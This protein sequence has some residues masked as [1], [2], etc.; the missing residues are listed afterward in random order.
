[1]V[2]VPSY[3]LLKPLLMPARA[4]LSSPLPRR[5]WDPRLSLPGPFCRGRTSP[6]PEA[7]SRDLVSVPFL[8]RP[9]SSVHC[10]LPNGGESAWGTGC[11]GWESSVHMY[12]AQGL[13]P[14][15]VCA[16]H[17]HMCVRACFRGPGPARS[18]VSVRCPRACLTA[19]CSDRGT[20][21][22]GRILTRERVFPLGSCGS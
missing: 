6:G 1:M 17:T 16:A 21:G 3:T 2:S 22:S 11:R 9:V 19:V 5:A 4:S 12:P 13:P 14:G 10:S 18:A 15:R 7:P 8:A 20:G